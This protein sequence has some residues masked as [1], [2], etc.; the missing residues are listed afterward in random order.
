MCATVVAA[1]CARCS[2]SHDGKALRARAE[3]GTLALCR[4]VRVWRM[5]L[6]C[7]LPSCTTVHM[8]FV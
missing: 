6:V 8:S 7:V 5:S 4:A 3:C 2:V 1:P